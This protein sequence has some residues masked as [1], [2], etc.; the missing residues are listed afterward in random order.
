MPPTAYRCDDPDGRRQLVLADGRRNGIDDVQVVTG[1]R[2]LL[3]RCLHPVPATLGGAAVRV[4]PAGP[5]GRPVEVDTARPWRADPA[6]LQVRLTAP[7]DLAPYR[8]VLIDPEAAGFDPRLAEAV[9]D[10]GVDCDDDLDCAGPVDCP[11]PG[12]PEPVIDY[13]SRD[14]AGLRQLLLDRLSVVAPGW[15]DRNPADIGVTLVELFAHLGDLL[16]AAQDAVAAEAYL[17]TARRRVSV[18]RHARM[19]DYRMHQ[20]AAAR[21]WLVLTVDADVSAGFARR[22][23]G[24]PAGHEVRSGDGSVVFHT[25]YP[26]TP[27]AARNTIDIHTWGQRRCSLPCGAT[28]ATLVGTVAG[29]GLSAGDMLVLEEIRGETA[30]DPPDVTHRWPVRLTSVTAGTDPLTG[31]DVVEVTWDAEDALPF[32]LRVRR[33]PRGRC[34]DDLPG[35]VAR[36]NVVLAGHGARVPDEPLVP[37]TA[38]FTGRYRPA[39]GRRGLAFAVP[40]TDDRTQPARRALRIDPELAVPDLIRVTDGR[41]DWTARDDLLGSERFAAEFVAETDDDGTVH[42]R[43]GDDVHGRRPVPGDDRRFRAAYR[44]GGGVAGNAGRNV[45]TVLDPPIAGVWVTN[46]MPAVGGAEPEPVEQVRQL[47]PQAFRTQQR[48]VTDD[49]YAGVARRDPRVQRAVA[50]RRWTGSWYTEYVTVDRIGGAGLDPGLR[51]DLAARLDRARM[52]GTDVEVRAPSYVPIEIVLSVCVAPGYFRGTVKLALV[53]RF[54]DR[55]RSGFFHPDNFTFAQP[56]FLSAVVA[57]AMSV[58]GVATVDV[59]RF[60]R[61]GRPDDDQR[62]SGRIPMDRVEVARC[63]SEPPDGSSGRITFVMAGGR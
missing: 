24:I 58:A 29:L 1:H 52:A 41:D 60:G 62:D 4:V 55:D 20:G 14:Y 27:V 50:T 15:T 40:Y 18:A 9:F 59:R 23:T 35:A 25:L 54:S 11:P 12:T 31:T 16:A 13:L 57:A 53:E 34:F 45:L 49:D 63:D 21:T 38:P 6:V 3:V 7:G 42:L 2:E 17:G 39:L 47:A 61:F 46:P 8:I 5:S 56:V 33:F 48:A 22:C 19:L 36:G 44:V 43:F 10:F 30:G 32:A 37:D 51:G 26:V 28:A